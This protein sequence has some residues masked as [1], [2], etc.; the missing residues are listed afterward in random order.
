V[1]PAPASR[2]APRWIGRWLCA[3]GGWHTAFG[4]W[5]FAAPLGRVVRA[6]WWNAVGWTGD[7]R[8]LAFWFVVAGALALILGALVDDAERQR[9]LVPRVCGWGLVALALAGGAAVPVSAFW[10]LLVP[11][12]GVLRQRD[13]SGV[14]A[15][16]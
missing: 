13:A 15:A 16:A 1:P 5:W 7:R 4:L 9:R 2:R 14:G 3:V 6:G 10:L 12:V 11:G 8:A